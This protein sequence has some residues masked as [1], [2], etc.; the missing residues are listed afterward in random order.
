MFCSVF[1]FVGVKRGDPLLKLKVLL[2]AHGG[3][4]C[5]KMEGDGD[6]DVVFG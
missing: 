3:G 2:P 6:G 1:F 4:G 5:I